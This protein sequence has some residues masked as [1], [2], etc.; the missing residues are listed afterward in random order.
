MKG[1]AAWTQILNEQAQPLLIRFA[2]AFC[3]CEVDR[4]FVLINDG[5][6]GRELTQ[7]GQKREKRWEQENAH[8][9][10]EGQKKRFYNAATNCEKTLII[11]H[12]LLFYAGSPHQMIFKKFVMTQDCRKLE[13]ILEEISSMG[14]GDPWNCTILNKH[15]QT[16]NHIE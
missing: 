12:P 5:A 16:A 13:E 3:R 7:N 6:A 11:H 1:V 9:L 8:S 14:S 2:A 15:L 10:A 4:F